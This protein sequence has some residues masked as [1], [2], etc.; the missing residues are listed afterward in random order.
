VELQIIAPGLKGQDEE[1]SWW[2]LKGQRARVKSVPYKS[3]LVASDSLLFYEP[4]P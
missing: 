3:T 1:E 2:P 4:K